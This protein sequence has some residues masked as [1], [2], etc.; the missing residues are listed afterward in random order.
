M[1]YLVDTPTGR[2]ANAHERA[3][4]VRPHAKET[5][6]SVCRSPDRLVMPLFACR[7]F[8]P[9]IVRCV[10]SHTENIPLQCGAVVGRCPKSFESPMADAKVSVRPTGF[11]Q[12]GSREVYDETRL[13][14]RE[15]YYA[16][17]ILPFPRQC[18]RSRTYAN[19]LYKH[20]IKHENGFAGIR[21]QTLRC[22]HEF[23]VPSGASSAI[24]SRDQGR[25]PSFVRRIFQSS[26][27]SRSVQ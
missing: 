17:A 22:P 8:E 5:L 13:D 1:I 9:L 15:K 14:V 24:W 4:E 21:R 20:V 18:S 2:R 25:F 16:K 12:D 7:A 3:R 26:Q 23:L 11:G 19:V 27:M 6:H 10:M